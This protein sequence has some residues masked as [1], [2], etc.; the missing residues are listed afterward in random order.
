MAKKKQHKKVQKPRKPMSKAWAKHLQRQAEQSAARKAANMAKTAAKH[1]FIAR[2][3]ESIA[4]EAAEAAGASEE[5]A[6][7][8]AKGVK[9]SKQ[10]I[11]RQ[12]EEA[13][14]NRQSDFVSRAENKRSQRSKTYAEQAKSLR[15]LLEGDYWDLAEAAAAGRYEEALQHNIQYLERKLEAVKQLQRRY[16]AELNKVD[17]T[18]DQMAVEQILD[19]LDEKQEEIEDVLYKMQHPI[20]AKYSGDRLGKYFKP[21]TQE[22]DLESDFM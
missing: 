8:L 14:K 3:R 11:R 12:V 19:D 9:G 21:S 1:E 13:L 7:D 2:K 4:R 22:T 5:V 17:N 10:D 6:R 15:R 16:N 20:S 18:E